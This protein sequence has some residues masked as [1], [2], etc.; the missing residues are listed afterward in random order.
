M[1]QRIQAFLDYVLEQEKISYSFFSTELKTNSQL[2][3]AA[4][5]NKFSSAIDRLLE[6]WKTSHLADNEVA[7]DINVQDSSDGDSNEDDEHDSDDENGSQ[8]ENSPHDTKQRAKRNTQV[9]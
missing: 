5:V 7:A 9:I 8:Q 2:F 3:S 4:N 6:R 1:D